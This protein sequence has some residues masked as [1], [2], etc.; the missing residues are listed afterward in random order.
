MGASDAIKLIE[1]LHVGGRPHM[2]TGSK[3][4]RETG[5]SVAIERDQAS[6]MSTV[7]IVTPAPAKFARSATV[8][9]PSGEAIEASISS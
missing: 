1:T 4:G 2:G 7:K 6:A 5:R 9:L 3:P 8:A